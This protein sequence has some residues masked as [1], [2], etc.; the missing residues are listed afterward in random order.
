[1]V[2]E[3]KKGQVI[4]LRG[5]NPHIFEAQRDFTATVG[6]TLYIGYYD[7]LSPD[8]LKFKRGSRFQAKVNEVRLATAE[9]QRWFYACREAG[10]YIPLDEI[11]IKQTEFK[12]Y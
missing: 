12:W 1:M 9:E 3:I 10:K 7:E 4:Y 11:K 2:L 5:G 8:E 6:S